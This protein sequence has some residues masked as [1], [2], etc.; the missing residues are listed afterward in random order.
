MVPKDGKR[1][2]L[3]ATA[4]KKGVAQARRFCGEGTCTYY[5]VPTEYLRTAGGP[6]DDGNGGWREPADLAIQYRGHIKPYNFARLLV[7]RQPRRKP[8]H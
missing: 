2:Q 7:L 3:H 5:V 1:G 4:K 8:P 6:N